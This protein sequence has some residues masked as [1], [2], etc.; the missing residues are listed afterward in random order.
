[1]KQLKK[2]LKLAFVA[3]VVALGMTSCS[4]DDEPEITSVTDGYT[5]SF[6]GSVSLV[7]GGQYTYESNITVT[8]V[9]G[10]NETITVTLPEYSFP[11]TLMGDVTLGE[12]TLRNLVYDAE[13]KGFSLNYGGE[14]VMQHFKAV[15]NGNVTMDADYPLN[16]PS[17][18]FVT[19]D[20][21]GKIT[22]ENSFKLGAMP[23]PLVE[24]FTGTK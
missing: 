17:D 4:R 10:E 16:T 21:N 24:S 2:L 13:R 18:I 19:L 23:L 20:G 7:I 6:N 8:I 12:L 9:K 11:N 3:T 14:G 5:G 22:V 15:R 1:M